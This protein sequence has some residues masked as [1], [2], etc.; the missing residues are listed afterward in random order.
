SSAAEE[1]PR[2]PDYTDRPDGSGRGRRFDAAREESMSEPG[3]A[4]PRGAAS[5]DLAMGPRAAVAAAG[6]VAVERAAAGAG[7]PATSAEQASGPPRRRLTDG[8]DLP[9]LPDCCNLGTMVRVLLPL[10]LGVLLLAWLL[11]AAGAS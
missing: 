9:V 5:P 1:G 2:E 8:A 4:A 3:P 6:A 11:P 7:A 10:N